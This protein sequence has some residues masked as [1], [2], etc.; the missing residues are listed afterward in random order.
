MTLLAHDFNSDAETCFAYLSAREPQ[1]EKWW[2]YRGFIR[3]KTDPESAIEYYRK[4]IELAESYIPAHIRL[5]KALARTGQLPAAEA[6]LK[7]ALTV[8]PQHAYVQYELAQVLIVQQKL[9]Q[10]RQMLMNAIQQPGW[11]PRP[12]WV[13]LSR[14][15]FSKGDISCATDAYQQ[16][17]RF[18][19]ATS[20]FSDPLLDAVERHGVLLR[21]FAQNAD[22]Y[23]AQGRWNEAIQAYQLLVK[24]RPDLA[25][26]RLNLAHCYAM[27]GNLPLALEIARQNT[28]LFPLNSQAWFSLA[29]LE[30][31]AGAP[32]DAIASYQKCLELAPQQVSAWF[33]LGLLYESVSD[34]PAAQQ[35]F[36]KAVAISPEHA[37]SRLALG[38]VLQ[39]Q[40][41]RDEAIQHLRIAVQLVPGDPVPQ[42]MMDEVLSSQN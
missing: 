19:E 15:C 32:S 14:L 29:T 38:S 20:E 8:D 23:L 16:V 5:A 27:Q 10:A 25:R 35:A 31:R 34:V 37:P 33:N 6:R 41:N 2:Y 39:K 17:A 30:E 1:S 11:Y 3:E 22:H 24:R 9:D 18:P 36:A 12:A 21:Q 7:A 40:G 26:P 28:T 13:S 4:T 42:A